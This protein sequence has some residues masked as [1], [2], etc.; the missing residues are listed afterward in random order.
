MFLLAFLFL[1][2]FP[3]II[4]SQYNFMLECF[5]WLPHHISLPQKY[6][7]FNLK[8]VY[9]FPENISFMYQNKSPDCNYQY[10]YWNIIDQNIKNILQILWLLNKSNNL[11]KIP[12]SM[13]CIFSKLVCVSANEYYLLIKWFSINTIPYFVFINVI[14]EKS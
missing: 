8:K 11:L 5:Y 1:Y 10:N 14:A 2:H 13:R 9:R 3:Y 12:L 6:I 7:N 4:V